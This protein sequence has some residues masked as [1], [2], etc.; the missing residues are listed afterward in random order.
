VS[1]FLVYVNNAGEVF[2]FHL[3][4]NTFVSSIVDNVANVKV[5]QTLARHST[6]TLTIGRYAHTQ[7]HDMQVALEAVLGSQSMSEKKRVEGTQLA[8]GT[9]GLISK[10]AQNKVQQLNSKQSA[11]PCKAVQH[12]AKR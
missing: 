2:N 5:T 11:N 3:F 6:P 9:D 10:H 4:R 7:L 8:T 12:H 1:D